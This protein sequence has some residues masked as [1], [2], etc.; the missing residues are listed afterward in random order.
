V[1]DSKG[2]LKEASLIGP[3]APELA[4]AALQEAYTANPYPP[5]PKEMNASEGSY[6][7]LIQYRIE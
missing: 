5:F 1:L 3:A 7:F 4:E 2:A 6:D